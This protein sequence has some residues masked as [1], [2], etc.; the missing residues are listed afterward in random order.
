MRAKA[1]DY[2]KKA[3]NADWKPKSAGTGRRK[4]LSQAPSEAIR[5]TQLARVEKPISKDTCV[6]VSSFMADL[7]P[8][9][10]LITP[11]ESRE[12]Q[13]PGETVVATV[14]LLPCISLLLLCIIALTTPLDNTP[15]HRR[16]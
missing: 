7:R 16:V 11:R 2:T 14:L 5:P 13:A 9:P 4:R 3:F 6:S 15:L 12:V 10:S 8:S 1:H